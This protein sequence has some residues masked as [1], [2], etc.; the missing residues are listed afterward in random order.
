MTASLNGYRQSLFR[1]HYYFRKFCLKMSA[2]SRIAFEYSRMTSFCFG[3]YAGISFVARV[4]Q[5]PNSH[6]L[7]SGVTT[8]PGNSKSHPEPQGET[9]LARR[10]SGQG[11]HDRIR[12]RCA[13]NLVVVGVCYCYRNVCLPTR[14]RLL[15]RGHRYQGSLR[16]LRQLGCKRVEQLHL[17]P[18]LSRQH[19][20][21]S[22][23]TEPTG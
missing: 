17:A 16:Q 12:R 20:I 2:W 11:Q 13:A 8:I 3:C 9:S 7:C 10:H 15:T 5:A 1:Y 4:N 6:T 22:I 18:S 19:H 14:I 21:L 23:W